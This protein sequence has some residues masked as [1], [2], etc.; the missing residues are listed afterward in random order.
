MPDIPKVVIEICC[1]KFNSFV[2]EY[3]VVKEHQKVAE[4]AYQK[5][6]TA[7]E[8]FKYNWRII[9]EYLD[10]GAVYDTNFV[11]EMESIL[12]KE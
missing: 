9:A 11:A 8:T 3:K 7:I 6:T 12:E 5:A 4:K 10:I 1:D 2:D